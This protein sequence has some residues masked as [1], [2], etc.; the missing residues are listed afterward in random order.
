MLKASIE[1][2]VLTLQGSL[3]GE[4]S[5]YPL[6]ESYLQGSR[7]RDPC[8]GLRAVEGPPALALAVVAARR[9]PPLSRERRPFRLSLLLCPGIR[10][11]A[12]G[13][14]PVP[15]LCS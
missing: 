5:P 13:P 12:A 1:G 10:Y 4:G 2:P 14:L 11:S 9:G 3:G 6:A 7:S 8:Q 15:E